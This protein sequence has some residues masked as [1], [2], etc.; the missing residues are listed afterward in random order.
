MSDVDDPAGPY[1]CFNI[2]FDLF[3]GC[4]LQLLE[5]ANLSNQTLHYLPQH[6]S[7]RPRGQLHRA[8][9]VHVALQRPCTM[10]KLD[11]SSTICKDSVLYVA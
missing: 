8:A 1:D 3:D 7:D 2:V 4:K 10:A 6:L 11:M 9:S 5:E